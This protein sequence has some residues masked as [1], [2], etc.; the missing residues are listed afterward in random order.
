MKI[1]LLLLIS[2]LLLPNVVF[3]DEGDTTVVGLSAMAPCAPLPTTITVLS[4]S[5]LC[6]NVP[7]VILSGS[8]RRAF[9]AAFRWEDGTTSGQ[10]RHPAG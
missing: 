4:A 7:T 5:T 9:S 10:D 6:G 8:W 2:A 3:A 1:I